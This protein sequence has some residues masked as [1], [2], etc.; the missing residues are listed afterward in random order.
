MGKKKPQN[1]VVEEDEGSEPSLE[2]GDIA[3]R[4]KGIQL[5]ETPLTPFQTE[6]LEK[7]KK[8]DDERLDLY[9]HFEEEMNSLKAKYEKKYE[10]LYRQRHE[11]LL[12]KDASLS[13]ETQCGT[14]GVPNFW[15]KAL[16]NHRQIADMI[17]PQDIPVLAHLE[18]ITADYLD[19]KERRS[20]RLTV[21]FSE[22]P[23]FEPTTLIKTYHVEADGSSDVLSR[24]E[25]TEIQWKSGK[26]VTKKLVTKKQKNKRTKAVRKITE[27]VDC[28]SFFNFFKSHEIP[29]ESEIEK[30]PEEAVEELEVMVEADYQAGVIIKD[31]II[32]NA[33]RWYTGEAEDS[34]GDY[35]NSEF[36]MDEEDGEDDDDFDDDEDDD[37]EEEAPKTK[38]KGGSPSKGSHKARGEKGSAPAAAG[39]D[40][41]DCKTQ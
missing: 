41:K 25:S 14:P 9:K 8:I 20:F 40:G 2:T 7:L 38:G 32:P 6:N 23:F 30:M 4:M 33:V 35:D 19:D 22:N 13:E 3:E 18:D 21:K 31:K 34:D 10:P 26:D 36:E 29:D 5:D 1:K 11:S 28:P 16:G 24:T 27:T 17:E 15:M 37:D 39:A 12:Q